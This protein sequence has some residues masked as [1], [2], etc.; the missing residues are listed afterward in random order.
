MKVPLLVWIPDFQSRR[1]PD[2][3][4][5]EERRNLDSYRAQMA[6]NADRIIL[7]SDD[8]VRD[9]AAFAPGAAFK[10]RRLAFVAQ[11]PA[12]VYRDD[13][14]GVCG[15]YHL[16][17]RFVYLPN[18]FWKHKNHRLVVQALDLLKSEYPDAV[19]VCTGSTHEYR[20]PHYFAELLADIAGRGLRDRFIIL[21]LVPHADLYRLMRQSLAV[22]QPSLFEGWSTTV[23]E[24]KSVGKAILLS[25]LPVHRE[26]DPPAALYFDPHDPA[27]LAA[28]L[29]QVCRE[30]RPGPDLALEAA[31]RAALPERTR[32]FADCFMNAVS[33]P[34]GPP[35]HPP[36]P[37]PAPGSSPAPRIVSGGRT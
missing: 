3:F 13:P 19:I 8:A 33:L 16:P 2:M 18:Q 34:G 11:V 32:A 27:A 29:A 14:A 28:G 24:A 35:C 7:S 4:P 37:P 5:A 22:L 9:F 1:L 12:E 26:Q 30:R 6:A 31:A 25:D 15:R 10:A 20:H 36:P 23:E 21:G 17:E